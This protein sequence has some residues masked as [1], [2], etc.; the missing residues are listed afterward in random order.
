MKAG[1]EDM[2]RE[3]DQS[4]DTKKLL[5]SIAARAFE[6]KMGDLE[7]R[8]MEEKSKK[9]RAEE[10]IKDRIDEKGREIGVFKKKVEELEIVA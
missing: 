7:V 8:E 9:L 2:K 5:E 10:A 4:D 3:L 1:L 6:R